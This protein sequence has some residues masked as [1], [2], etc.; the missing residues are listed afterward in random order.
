MYSI[1]HLPGRTV[2]IEGQEWLY[3]SGTAYLGIPHDE[4]FRHQLLEGINKYGTN[5]G[6]SRLGNPR[7]DV[8]EKAEE[9]LAQLCSA[10]KVLTLSSGSIAGQVLIRYL[11]EKN[12]FH[13]C[14]RGTSCNLGI[15]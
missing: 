2:S 14:P 12:E 5:F 6:G 3:F 13:L 9:S 15:E 1:N 11:E 7:L 10:E 8:Y 4:G